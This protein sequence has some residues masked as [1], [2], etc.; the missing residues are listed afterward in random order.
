MFCSYGKTG[1]AISGVTLLEVLVALGIIL[2][3]VVFAMTIFPLG[4]ESID[5]NQN[6]MVATSIADNIIKNQK[7]KDFD[8]ILPISGSQSFERVKSG[9]KDYQ[10]FNYVITVDEKQSGLKY[11]TSKVSW[12]TKNK[13]R[14]V[15]VQTIVFKR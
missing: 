8:E 14:Y 3:V 1:P 12:K 4:V 15:T 9:L 5:N 11:L 6:Y 13:Q 10:T 7:H 2:L